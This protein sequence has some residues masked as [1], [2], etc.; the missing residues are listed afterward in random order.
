MEQFPKYK[1][2]KQMRRNGILEFTSK[3]Q[4][5]VLENQ[6]F[7]SVLN[8]MLK[9]PDDLNSISGFYLLNKTSPLSA[10]YYFIL[11]FFFSFL[12]YLITFS[13]LIFIFVYLSLVCP[14]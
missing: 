5:K 1:P 10:F 4:S 9:L 12:Q 6:N 14:R 13:F 3:L 7:V 8:E 11:I 2:S